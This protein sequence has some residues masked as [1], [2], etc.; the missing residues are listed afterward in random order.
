M[1]IYYSVT[2][3]SDKNFCLKIFDRTLEN[4]CQRSA[5]RSR[6]LIVFELLIDTK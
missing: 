4:M 5:I 1:S 3:K 2:E 6:L